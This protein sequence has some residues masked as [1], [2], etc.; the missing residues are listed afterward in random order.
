M[1]VR[2]MTL[3]NRVAVSDDISEP[4]TYYITTKGNYWAGNNAIEQDTRKILGLI[5]D[6]ETLAGEITVSIRGNFGSGIDIL[7]KTTLQYSEIREI[8][9]KLS[10]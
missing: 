9:R 8:A 7:F 5:L 1:A 2:V 3:P 4:N 10:E 6:H